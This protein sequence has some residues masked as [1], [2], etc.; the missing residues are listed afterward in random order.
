KGIVLLL[1]NGRP[2]GFAKNIGR[3]ANNLYPDALRLRLDTRALTEQKPLIT[4]NPKQ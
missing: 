2:L 1:H 3:R 4:L